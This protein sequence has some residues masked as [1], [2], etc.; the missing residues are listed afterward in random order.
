MSEILI[1]DDERALREGLKA[2]L[3]SEGF[4]VR[5]ARDGEE[6]LKRIAESR[7]HLVLLDVMMPKMNGFRCCE[8]IRKRD[9]LLP[10]VF[11]TA[12]DTEADQV[13]A[14]GLGGD[15]YVSKSASD[16]ILLVRINRALARARDLDVCAAKKR[17]DMLEFGSVTVDLRSYTVFSKD[18]EALAYLT[19]TEADILRFLS[20]HRGVLMETDDIITALRGKGYACEDAMLY[21]HMY[22]VRRKLGPAGGLLVNK[23]RVGYALAEDVV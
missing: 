19:K 16:A 23:R 6:A 8:E 9:E 13:R 5:M 10:V 18:G 3:M 1:V 21:Q 4:A 12:K 17:G 22:A 20:A 14:M 7:P 11:L 15:D 2:T